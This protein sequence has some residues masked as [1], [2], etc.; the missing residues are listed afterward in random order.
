M[1]ISLFANPGQTITVVIQVVDFDG[2]LQDG[3]QAPT[4]DFVEMPSG[5]FAAGYP[6]S[7]TEITLG[8]WQQQI[9]IP[10]GKNGVGS[11]VV[12]CS[13]PH[14][15]TDLLQNEIFIV[16]VALPFGNTSVSFS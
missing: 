10:S 14:P 6:M 5:G 16:N 15:D 8:I 1:P 2:V 3:Y 4:V 12:S 9:I 13:W 7:M 11:Y